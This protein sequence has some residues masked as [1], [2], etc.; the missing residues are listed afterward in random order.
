MNGDYP[1]F[2]LYCINMDCDRS[3]Y[4]NIN[5]VEVPFNEINLS[6]THVCIV[7]N[8]PIIST[9]DMEIEN[10]VAGVGVRL[11]GNP[12]YDTNY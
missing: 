1:L 10:L 2:S 9:M 5:R 8:S 3:I 12:F 7:C 6:Q 4:N 11:Y